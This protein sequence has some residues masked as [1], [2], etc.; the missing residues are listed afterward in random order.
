V[1]RKPKQP[2]KRLPRNPL[3]NPK[4][5]ELGEHTQ[6]KPGQSG[7]PGGRPKTKPITEALRELLASVGPVLGEKTN[8]QSLADRLLVMALNGDLSAIRELADR[9]EGKVNTTFSGPDGG[10]IPLDLSLDKI[11]ER[12][13]ELLRTGSD[14]KS[15]S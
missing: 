10:G 11:N 2:E 13:A 4:I 9:V 1:A 5:V 3:G 12:I 14:R 6:F 7:N 15:S 8:A